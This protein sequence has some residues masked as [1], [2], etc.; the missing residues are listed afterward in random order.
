MSRFYTFDATLSNPGRSAAW[1]VQGE[2]V[3]LADQGAN[4]L[5]G[6]ILRDGFAILP[7]CA[8][9]YERNEVK[10]TL[11]DLCAMI[12]EGLAS[13]KNDKG[14]VPMILNGTPLDV[15]KNRLATIA[16]RKASGLVLDGR[17]RAIA[18]IMAYGCGCEDIEMQGI[19]ATPE[20][21]THARGIKPNILAAL[22]SKVDPWGK[23]E[24]AELMLAQSPTCKESEIMGETGVLRGDAQLMHRAASAIRKHGLVPDRSGRCLGKEEWKAV[25]ECATAG[26]AHAMLSSLQTSVRAKVMGWDVIKGALAVMP[27]GT[28]I[29]ART[30]AGCEDRKALDTYLASITK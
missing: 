5:A 8:V 7:S 22:A 10:L 11:A 26:E 16:D 4:G 18:S 19:E 17:R 21:A 15:F 12:V 2:A 13:R 1:T 25:L 28:M 29:D 14:I 24:A 9:L 27:E 20:Q 3:R 6:S 23:V 30:L